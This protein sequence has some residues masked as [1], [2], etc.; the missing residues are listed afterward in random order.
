MFGLGNLFSGLGNLFT[1]PNMLQALDFLG[2]GL[3]I[4]GQINS[5]LKQPQAPDYPRLD[6]QGNPSQPTPSLS[7][8]DTARRF[9]SA[10]SNMAERGIGPG[11]AF[12]NPLSTAGLGMFSESPETMYAFLAQGQAMPSMP[13]EDDLYGGMY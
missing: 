13:Y 7:P 12:N 1:V 6:Q 11:G 2:G 3:D 10:R 5:L 9:A 8:E 4:Y